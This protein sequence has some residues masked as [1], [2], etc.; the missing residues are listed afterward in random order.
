MSG[1]EVTV[2][3]PAG[4]SSRFTSLIPNL[5][6]E[7]ARLDEGKWCIRNDSPFF[8]HLAATFRSENGDGYWGLG[9]LRPSENF[10]LDWQGGGENATLTGTVLPS[11]QEFSGE[12]IE[13]DVHRREAESLN[14]RK[15]EHLF[16]KYLVA[17]GASCRRIAEGATK[18][19][20]FCVSLSGQTVPIEFKEFHR[21]PQEQRSEALMRTRGYGEVRS[22]EPGHRIM[23][24]A[25]TA[26]SQ[27]HS[28][29][30]KHGLGPGILAIFDSSA[31][32]H[33]QPF[34]VA[35]FFEG[36]LTVSISVADLSIA[37]VY[38][39]ENRRRAPYDRNRLLSAIA[40]FSLAP[41]HSSLLQPEPD[42][43]IANLAIYHNP[44]AAYPLCPDLLAPLGFP[45]YVIG[46][47]EPPDEWADEWA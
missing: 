41:R 7:F 31:L 30:K 5:R 35:A 14:V 34:D 22:S 4:V 43:F 20:D 33:A 21:S 29:F 15:W 36:T 44:R 12:S 6:T 23:K 32:G 9:V 16:Y 45:Q 47:A 28:Y 27:L 25:E 24:L 13:S 40:N 2:V 37:N 26:R 10:E 19:P 3:A 8:L 42:E 39:Q 18:S 11:A 38:R 17:T 46:H 1:P